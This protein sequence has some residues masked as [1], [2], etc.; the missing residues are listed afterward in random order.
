MSEENNSQSN[1]TENKPWG[2]DQNTFCMLMHLTVLFYWWILPLIMWLTNKDKNE[3]VNSH[4]K[5]IANFLISIGIYWFISSILSFL[6]IG[7]FIMPILGILAFVFPI[8]A[9]L[10][11]N[12]GET[13]KYPITIQFIK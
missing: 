6:L 8:I 2:M 11:A 4:G 13:Y 1:V 7:F 10:K 3:F 9:A 12:K 5:A